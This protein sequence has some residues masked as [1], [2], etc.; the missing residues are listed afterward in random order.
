MHRAIDLGA[1]L[2][3]LSHSQPQPQLAIRTYV[4]I[5]EVLKHRGTARPSSP[6]R[7]NTSC[8]TACE[9]SSERLVSGLNM[10]T[11]SGSQCCP[12]IR[13]AMVVSRP[14]RHIRRERA[15]ALGTSTPPNLKIV[16]RPVMQG[17]AD[18]SPSAG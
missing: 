7:R 12:A 5:D 10:I 6:S 4:P 14:K 8:A 16:T 1:N 2:A 3:S 18:L 15:R 17:S 13:S 9:T 11:R